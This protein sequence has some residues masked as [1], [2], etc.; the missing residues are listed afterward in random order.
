MNA[1]I[2][3]NNLEGKHTRLDNLCCICS[4]HTKPKV[5]GYGGSWEVL[6]KNIFISWVWENESEF[7]S[8][9]E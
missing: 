1:Y 3:Q 8:C 4:Y 7:S 5:G 6:R 9:F 2:I